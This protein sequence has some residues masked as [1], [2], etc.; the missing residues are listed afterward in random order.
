MGN[1]EGD[2]QTRFLC[3]AWKLLV[4][5]LH[6]ATA[7]IL[8]SP[9]RNFSNESAQVIGNAAVGYTLGQTAEL[10]VVGVSAAITS[11]QSSAKNKDYEYG[12]TKK[13]NEFNS[14]C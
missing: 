8:T 12:Q 14:L 6:G 9:K 11:K 13:K 10:A 4:H 3:W 7:N 2:L 5:M 1:T